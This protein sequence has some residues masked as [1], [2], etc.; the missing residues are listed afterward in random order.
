MNKKNF[1]VGGLVA[2]AGLVA[3]NMLASQGALWR[4]VAAVAAGGLALPFAEK[5][6]A[7]V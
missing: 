3:Y 6:A 5:V 4:G 2:A 1:V 7:K